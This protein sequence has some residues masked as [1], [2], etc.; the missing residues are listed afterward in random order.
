MHCRGT[1]IIPQCFSCGSESKVFSWNFHLAP[2]SVPL[3]IANFLQHFNL[4]MDVKEPRQVHAQG[5]EDVVIHASSDPV[6]AFHCTLFLSAPQ[7][8]QKLLSEF[9]DVLSSNGFT[10]S[11]PCH[12]VR[13]HLLTNPGPP[14]YA[15]PR[16]LDLKKLA[17]AKAEFSSMEKAGI[18]RRS[19]SPWSPPLHME[20]KKDG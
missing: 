9:L 11:K 6:P 14:V 5:P 19:S 12:G 3:L 20:K 2:V 8:I 13:H 7:L 17:A 16:S 15:K 18:I 1:R 10:T 4:L